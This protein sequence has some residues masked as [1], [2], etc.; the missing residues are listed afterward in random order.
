MNHP[1]EIR[2]NTSVG[3]CSHGKTSVWGQNLG[4]LTP[5]ICVDPYPFVVVRRVAREIAGIERV[6]V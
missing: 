2:Y 6:I 4:G 5:R 3:A 1:A